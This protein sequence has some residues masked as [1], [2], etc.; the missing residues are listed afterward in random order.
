MP[1]D[2]SGSGFLLLS[3]AAQYARVSP[4]TVRRWLAKGLPYHQAGTGSRV[5]IKQMDLEQFLTRHDA[6]RHD[7][8]AMIKAVASSLRLPGES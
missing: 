5:L 4:R 8:V 1:A 7:L 6:Q 3:E 2:F